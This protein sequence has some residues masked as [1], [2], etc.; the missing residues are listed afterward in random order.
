MTDKGHDLEFLCRFVKAAYQTGQVPAV[1]REHMNSLAHGM[2]AAAK[3]AQLFDNKPLEQSCNAFAA[4][5]YALANRYDRLSHEDTE[6]LLAILKAMVAPADPTA[7]VSKM[8][9]PEVAAV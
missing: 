1:V 8:Q 4:K 7:P 3:T 6:V 9:S 5:L 2:E